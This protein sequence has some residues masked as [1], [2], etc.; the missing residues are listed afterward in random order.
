MAVDAGVTRVERLEQHMEE[1]LKSWQRRP[2]VEA[3]MA[4]RGFKVVAAM[5]EIS[6]LGNLSRF[7]HPRQMMGYLG[8]VSGEDSTGERRRQGAITKTGN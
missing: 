4:F 5:T 1:T 2:Y 3:L 7:A 8:M 6:E